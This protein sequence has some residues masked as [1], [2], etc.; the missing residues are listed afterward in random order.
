MLLFLWPV[1][2]LLALQL[3][4]VARVCK[5]GESLSVLKVTKKTS[6]GNKE[7][8]EEFQAIFSTENGREPSVN[9]LVSSTEYW[10]ENVLMMGLG[11]I[12]ARN[13]LLR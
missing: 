10:H 1:N 11:N 13:L 7:Q 12:G 9:A 6:E 5:T 3:A 2:L 4:S 8:K